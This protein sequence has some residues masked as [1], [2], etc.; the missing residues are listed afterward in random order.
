MRSPRRLW[1]DPRQTLLLHAALA[2]V[3]AAA[4]AWAR[5]GAQEFSGPLDP[6]SE[7]LL[8]LV[9]SNL[10]RQ[11]LGDAR[12]AAIAS[13]HQA[14]REA[15]A[16]L[17]REGQELLA[18]L[19]AAG[20]PATVLKGGA[21]I[22]GSY[23]DIGDRPL[24]D[25]D[26]LV[27]LPRIS[28]ACRAMR[29]LGFTAQ[30]PITP[31]A[32]RLTHAAQWR[33][34]GCAPVDLHWHVFE[35][36]CQ[37]HDDDD[38]WEAAVSMDMGDAR[39][40]VLCAEDQVIHVCVHGEKWV[41]VPGIRW[42]ADAVTILRRHQIRWDRLVEHA[43][44]RRF[45]LRLRAQLAYLAAEFAAP[46]PMEA[47]AALSSAPTSYLERFEHRFAVR[48]RRRPWAL[49]YWCN[50]LRATPGGPLAA[51][52]TFPRYLQ[53]VWRLESLR[54]VP[55]AGMARLTRRGRRHGDQ[56]F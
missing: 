41:N 24:S 4:D 17:L 46:V 30:S 49:V 18:A 55:S 14:T 33:R 21:L 43:V 5:L 42:V 26:V 9:W 45:A 11:G 47:L 48:D 32:L 52:L 12:L 39:G 8:P 35:E 38:L 10:T 50:H 20:I 2:R 27:P 31:A 25:L 28:D 53:A 34:P 15:N 6:G 54:Q 37:A 44:R 19:D 36:C 51:A 56:G 40:R 29:D 23:H 16:A 13:R 7:L 3:P 1:P 22:A